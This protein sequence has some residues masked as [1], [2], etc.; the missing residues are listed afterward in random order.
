MIPM[1]AQFIQYELGI[2][3]IAAA[4]LPASVAAA[5]PYFKAIGIVTTLMFVWV[6]L[7]SI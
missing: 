7:C 4:W 6:G 5:M 1:Q 2:P 3:V